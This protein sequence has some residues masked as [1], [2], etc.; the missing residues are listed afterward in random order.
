MATRSV[1]PRLWFGLVA[2][3]AVIAAGAATWVAHVPAAA[4]AVNAESAMAASD[5]QPALAGPGAAGDA[6]VDA[7]PS[8][9][10][11]PHSTP[12]RVG[13]AAPSQVDAERPQVLTL[14]S[15]AKM[16]VRISATATTGELR[17][18]T[19]INQAGWWDGGARLGDPFG[20]IVL[21]AHVDSFTQGIG[22][23]AELLDVQPGDALRLDSRHLSG[24]FRVVSARLVPKASVTA[25]SPVYSAQGPP[26]LVLIT[27]GGAYDPSAGGYQSNM[28][29]LAVP[30]GQLAAAN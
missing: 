7:W 13:E 29:V 3:L 22:R 16:N 15:G 2:V 14:P 26:R 11:V 9:S 8:A 19:D 24:R 5:P 17:I 21:A 4:S 28:V 12:A 25:T 18:P 23:F 30:E 27:C 6:P 1:K 20:A 10:R